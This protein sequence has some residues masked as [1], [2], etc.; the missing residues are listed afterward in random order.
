MRNYLTNGRGNFGFDFFDDVFDSFFRPTVY[1][2]HKGSM[3]TDI[4]ET[5]KDF[6]L[7]V[8]MPGFDKKDINL[9]LD[10]GYLT[11]EAKREEREEDNKNYLKRER[12]FSC[13][14]SF[15]VGDGVTEDDIG[16]KYENGTLVLVVPKKEKQIPPKKQIEI[17]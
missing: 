2:G 3:K 1:G 4:K 12:S 6:E 13:S 17:K 14:R 11:V 5:E 7:S 10:G 15:Y 9:T 8:D 16:A